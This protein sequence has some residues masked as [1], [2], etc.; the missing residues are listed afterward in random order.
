M[1]QN[2]NPL[3]EKGENENKLGSDEATSEEL[4]AALAASPLVSHLIELRGRVLK[5]L[6]AVCLVFIALFYFANDIYS[7]L[8]LPL[9]AQLPEGSTM[10]A[11]GIVSPFLAPFK[12][13][14]VVSLFVAMPVVLHQ[15]WSF[16]APGLYK[17][18]KKMA[19]PLLVLSIVL[20]YGGIAF[21][22]L[23]VFPL[24]MSFLMHVGPGSV[25][26]MPDINEY[27]SIALKLFFAF[28][29]AFEIPVATIMLVW[30]GVLSVQALKE[31]RPYVLVG[32]FVFGML[33]TPPDV[34]SQ[35]MLALPMYALFELGILFSHIPLGKKESDT[36][37]PEKD[38]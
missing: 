21:A 19:I 22:Y 24:V 4:Q 30:S 13:T 2:D 7:L 31:K 8:A 3:N 15:I 9:Q 36:S 12:L 29:L 5:A 32:C 38:A 28:G 14:L 25:Q 35:I 17:H 6:L 16:V 37:E 1:T 26:V 33:L 23:V 10:I 20:F 34:V 18:E 27:L 11:T